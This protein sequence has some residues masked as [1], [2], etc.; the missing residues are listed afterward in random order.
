MT[1]TQQAGT[2]ITREF[3]EA[4]E[5]AGIKATR[6]QVSKHRNGYG[7]LWN[8]AGAEIGAYVTR[9]RRE[10]AEAEEA[11]RLAAEAQAKAQAAALAALENATK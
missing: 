1:T 4:C 2:V 5:F 6:R 11:A 7:A 9:K 10:K 8:V 3:A